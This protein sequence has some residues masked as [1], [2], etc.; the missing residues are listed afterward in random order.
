M[1]NVRVM[2]ALAACLALPCCHADDDW[3]VARPANVGVNESGLS[4]MDAYVQAHLPHVRSLLVARHGHLVFEKYYGESRESLQNIQSMTK[5]ISSALLGIALRKGQVSSLDNKVL[6]YFPEYRDT[7]TDPRVKDITI[8]QLLTMSSGIAA[9]HGSFDKIMAHPVPD[10]LRQRLLFAPGR[11]FKYSDSGA[12]L[13]GAVLTKATG[14]SVLEFAR[15]EL[16]GPL[17]V[18]RF[19]WYAD[20]VG[21]SSGGMSG[22]FRARDVL[23]F[24]ELYL[25]NGKWNGRQIVPADFVVD[26]VKV[27]AAG[28]FFGETARYGYM[29]WIAKPGGYDAFYARGYGGQY[30]MVIQKL[31][32]VIL[33]TSDWR[34]PEY[35]EH[36]ALIERF[37]LPA[38]VSE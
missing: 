29:W 20:N 4:A 30:L 24:G 33:C 38:V 13:L 7:V 36:F 28:N 1:S 18:Q 19:I 16:F 22:L 14:T 17:G 32:L 31:D 35:P 26:S 6:D 23:S 34:Q 15:K 37:I 25:R 10:T 21:I 3:Q 27:H 8:R 11:G 5:S 12:H 9:T 2:V